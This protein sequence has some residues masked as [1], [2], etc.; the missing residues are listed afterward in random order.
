MFSPKTFEAPHSTRAVE[1]TY[2]Q[3]G[4]V[5]VVKVF[6]AVWIGIMIFILQPLLVVIGRE[7]QF[8]T[9]TSRIVSKML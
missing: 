2:A 5:V 6:F 1:S 9:S 8:H 7:N 4:K 3:I